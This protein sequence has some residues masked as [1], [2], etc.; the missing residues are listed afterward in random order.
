MR[1]PQVL[2]V[3]TSTQ[4]RAFPTAYLAPSRP[5]LL[6]SSLFF[7]RSHTKD[8][9]VTAKNEAGSLTALLLLAECP[10][11]YGCGDGVGCSARQLFVTGGRVSLLFSPLLALPTFPLAP[12]DLPRGGVATRVVSFLVRIVC[13]PVCQGVREVAERIKT[14]FLYPIDPYWDRLHGS[15]H[16]FFTTLAWT[17]RRQVVA[18]NYI[19]T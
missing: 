8:K 7:A 6:L 12:P 1:S 5:V 19:Q 9:T 10:F 4:W 14:L 3:N 13:I 17:K 11:R 16:Q 15:R 2:Q 18:C